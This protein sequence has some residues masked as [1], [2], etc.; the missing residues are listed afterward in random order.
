M[1]EPAE[2]PL[3]RPP[4]EHAEGALELP[5]GVQVL[6]GSPVGGRRGV[7]VLV[8]KFNGEI[9]TRLLTSALEELERAGVPRE[10][11]T[12]RPYPSRPVSFLG[13]FVKIRIV[14]RPRSARIWL[15]I[16]HSRASAG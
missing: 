4:E 7:A 5:D 8:A 14:L 1:T 11:V 10:S 2:V 13:L 3:L 9:T 16:P 12:V 6:E 15:P